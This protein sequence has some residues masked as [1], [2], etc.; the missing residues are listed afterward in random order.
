MTGRF[1]DPRGPVVPARVLI[2]SP[3]RSSHSTSECKP[4]SHCWSRCREGLSRLI[5]PGARSPRWQ[6]AR[7][8]KTQSN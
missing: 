1:R 2:G 5:R 4:M 8:F 7:C 3:C 6:V